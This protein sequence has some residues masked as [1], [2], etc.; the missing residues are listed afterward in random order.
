M[1]ITYYDELSPQ[2]EKRSFS[3][4]IPMQSHINTCYLPNHHVSY[5]VND[6]LKDKV[7]IKIDTAF[8]QCEL[9]QDENGHLFIDFIGNQGLSFQ[10]I[11]KIIKKDLKEGKLYNYDF[12]GFFEIT[13]E[14][15][16]ENLNQIQSNRYYCYS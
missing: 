16:N 3:R 6:D 7:Q 15:S 8:Q 5:Q 11:F 2:I 13:I 9:R 4:E 10:E 14:S 1:H 12:D